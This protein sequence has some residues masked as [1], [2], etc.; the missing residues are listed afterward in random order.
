MSK[1]QNEG[2]PLEKEIPFWKY[3]KEEILKHFKQTLSGYSKEVAA[4]RLKEF[5]SNELKEE[6]QESIFDK[7][8][9]Q[10]EDLLVRILLGAAIVSFILALTSSSHEEGISAFIEPLVILLILIANASIGVWQDINADKAI[11]ALKKLQATHTTVKRDNQL[12]IIDSKDVVPGDIVHLKEGEKIPA[13]LRFLE[14]DTSNFMVNQSS[15]TGESRQAYKST[16][17]ISLD[18]VLIDQRLNIG[19]GSSSVIYGQGIGI[20]IGT[21]MNTQIGKVHQM[22]ESVE[23]DKSPLK[24][25]LDEF[26]NYLTYLIGAICLIVWAMNF[27][28]FYDDIHGGFFNGCI[29][30]FKIAVALAV[31]AIPEGLPAVIT[32]CLA[33]GSK[34]MADCNAI[35]RKLDSI[36]TLGCTN[37]ICSDKTGTLTTNNMT[38]TKI[39]LLGN[40][41]ETVTKNVSGISYEPEGTVE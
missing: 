14:I 18:E 26:G 17:V 3:T 4:Q 36:E 27:R 19:F 1:I 12:Y 31:A 30:Y 2:Q 8:K 16:D 28:N 37:V 41:G 11:D 20:V 25:K 23:E 32:T 7:I 13:D 35:V 6:E 34:R 40:N 9:E 22:I 24:K 21:G 38:V 33:L 10:F 5:G 39:L 15:F 29:Y